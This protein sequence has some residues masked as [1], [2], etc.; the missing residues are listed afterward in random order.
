MCN[1]YR[2]TVATLLSYTVTEIL[3]RRIT[4]REASSQLWVQEDDLS[5]DNDD[6]VKEF[7]PGDNIDDEDEEH[8][9]SVDDEGDIEVFEERD[10]DGTGDEE[11]S[12]DETALAIQ[13]DE[14]EHI[15]DYIQ[16]RSG[17]TYT[18]LSRTQI[19]EDAK[20]S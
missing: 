20:I 17:I 14:E 18:H 1:R 9:A 16:S 6:D 8:V 5:I 2:N 13:S 3:S 7:F 15:F 4:L 10:D 19:E 11:A 12:T